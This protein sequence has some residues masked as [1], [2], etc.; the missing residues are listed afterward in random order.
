MESS[1]LWG[2]VIGAV[3]GGIAVLIATFVAENLRRQREDAVKL[4]I[5]RADA[6]VVLDVCQR[7]EL[8]PEAQRPAWLSAYLSGFS[9]RWDYSVVV[10]EETAFKNLIAFHF[11]LRFAMTAA[12]ILQDAEKTVRELHGKLRRVSEREATQGP[13]PELEEDP[14]G[15]ARERLGKAAVFLKERAG[16]VVAD[17]DR[18]IADEPP[19]ADFL[20]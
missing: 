6:V 13:P 5:L 3:V 19:T 9:V 17:L 8:R 14:L 11:A 7:A 12:N 16:K 2:G 1:S 15:E 4:R 20:G 10:R 18:L